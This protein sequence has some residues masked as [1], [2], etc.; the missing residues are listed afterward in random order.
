MHNA[1]KLHGHTT[2]GDLERLGQGNRLHN[3][4]HLGSLR[5]TIAL[6]TWVLRNLV[7]LGTPVS[8]KNWSGSADLSFRMSWHSLPGLKSVFQIQAQSECRTLS[9]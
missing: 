5:L 7:T 2:I 9:K 3:I 8:S 1:Y 4:R 6:A